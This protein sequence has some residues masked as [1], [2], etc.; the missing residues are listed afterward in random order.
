MYWLILLFFISAEGNGLGSIAGVLLCPVLK[1]KVG[2]S[3]S[4][5]PPVVTRLFVGRNNIESE[6]NMAFLS[7]QAIVSPT[8]KLEKFG[9]LANLSAC[10]FSSCATA[11]V[12]RWAGVPCSSHPPVIAKP[13]RC[14]LSLPLLPER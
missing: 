5:L 9:C 12:P 1:P 11:I 2:H 4:V 8:S 7:F 14:L 6:L 10:I 13:S 3:D